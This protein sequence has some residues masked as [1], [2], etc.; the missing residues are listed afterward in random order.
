MVKVKI[1]KY[2]GRVGIKET[3]AC[4]I[5]SNLVGI[6]N[7]MAD[8]DIDVDA[9]AYNLAGQRVSKNYRGVVVKNGKEIHPRNKIAVKKSISKT[10]Y[11]YLKQSFL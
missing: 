6:N 10:P 2:M 1:Q 7:I 8:A 9:P 4:G 3:G 11:I 5:D